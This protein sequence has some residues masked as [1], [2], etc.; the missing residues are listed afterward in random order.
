MK[1]AIVQ[2]VLSIRFYARQDDVA[3]T[4]YAMGNSVKFVKELEAYT[5][6]PYELNLMHSAAIPDFQS[7]KK[8]LQTP[9]KFPFN[10]F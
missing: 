4:S 3:R 5:S 2:F 1:F 9:K 7:G 8:F 10:K 6:F